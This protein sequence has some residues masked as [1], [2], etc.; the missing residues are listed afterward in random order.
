MCKISDYLLM[1]SLFVVIGCSGSNTRYDQ[2]KIQSV[3]TKIDQNPKLTTDEKNYAKRYYDIFIVQS[4]RIAEV[5]ERK[6]R[7]GNKEPFTRQIQPH[8]QYERWLIGA[9]PFSLYEIAYLDD[10]ERMVPLWEDW[11]KKLNLVDINNL[12][13]DAKYMLEK[14]H[15][16]CNGGPLNWRK[17][18]IKMY[19]KLTPEQK[20]Y[21]DTF[22]VLTGHDDLTDKELIAVGK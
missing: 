13:Q 17:Q 18:L 7:A 5:A 8:D 16:D 11:Q 9:G 6:A 10:I 15:E 14:A 22:F 3:Y 1:G 21:C 19:G 2:A 12:D 4:G 20:Q